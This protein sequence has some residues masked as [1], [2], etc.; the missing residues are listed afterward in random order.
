[1]ARVGDITTY[2]NAN[3]YHA[4]AQQN[5]RCYLETLGTLHE[6]AVIVL[7]S[8]F[9]TYDSQYPCREPRPS[10]PNSHEPN[11]LRSDP[12]HRRQRP[13]SRSFQVCRPQSNSRRPPRPT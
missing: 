12:P 3:G 11:D 1:K 2:M 8:G 5:V 4:Y 6:E 10:R 13:A 9:M 7:S